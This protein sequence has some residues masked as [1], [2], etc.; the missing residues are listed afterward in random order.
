M[1][2]IDVMGDE[3]IPEKKTEDNPSMPTS[4][5]TSIPS[6]NLSEVSKTRPLNRS[7]S[8]IIKISKKLPS[9]EPSDSET[10]EST[11]GCDIPYCPVH[12]IA[13]LNRL[14][15]KKK[16]FRNNSIILDRSVGDS[17]DNRNIRNVRD[18]NDIDNKK[19]SMR[20][21]SVSDGHLLQPI[22][23]KESQKKRMREFNRHSTDDTIRKSMEKLENVHNEFH[24]IYSVPPRP[25]CPFPFQEDV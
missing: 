9:P 19:S 24:R 15:E 12:G 18:D 10:Y 5:P 2:R 3:V 8:N 25:Q 23:I 20:Y 13:T 11:D 4:I 6:V 16:L 17:K 7:L 14:E 22:C 21:R 1:Q